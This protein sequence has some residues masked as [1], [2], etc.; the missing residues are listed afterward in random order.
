MLIHCPTRTKKS[1]CQCVACSVDASCT[2][3]FRVYRMATRRSR[4]RRPTLDPGDTQVWL[5]WP[6]VVYWVLAT[7]CTTGWGCG[8]VCMTCGLEAARS[9]VI[10]ES[11]ILVSAGEDVR[12]CSCTDPLGYIQM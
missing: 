5:P 3:T 6:R 10:F 9:R 7:C 2:C 11:F 1:L 4:A 8:R 12:S